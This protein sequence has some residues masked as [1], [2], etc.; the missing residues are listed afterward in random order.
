MKDSISKHQIL[1]TNLVIMF[2]TVAMQ[3]MGKIKNPITDKIERDLEQAQ[4]SID[5]LEM[6]QEKTKGS[7]T[8]VEQKMLKSILHEL[9][10]N[11]L[12]EKDRNA[13]G[14]SESDDEKP[15]EKSPDPD[16]KDSV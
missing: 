6:L 12:E 13:E 11:F 8:D 10:L 5:M 1:F 7:L 3:Q 14:K 4:M 2:Q 15:E 16:G 9:H